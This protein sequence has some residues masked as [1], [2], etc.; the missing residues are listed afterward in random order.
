MDASS[1]NLSFEVHFWTPAKHAESIA[2]TDKVVSRLRALFFA[3]K[4]QEAS[5]PTAKLRQ[6]S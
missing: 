6:A 4:P 1:D 3:A 2:A 5:Q